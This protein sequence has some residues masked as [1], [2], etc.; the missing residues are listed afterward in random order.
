MQAHP[1][2][3]SDVEFEYFPENTQ[4]N[5]AFGNFTE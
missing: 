2:Q 4:A 5:I 1:F 3:Q